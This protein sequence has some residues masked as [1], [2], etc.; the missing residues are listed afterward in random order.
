MTSQTEKA[1]H[2]KSLHKADN[3]LLLYNIWD[4]GSANAVARAG[5][6]A[7][8][9]SSWSVAAAQGYEDGEKLPL[10]Q[11]LAVATSIVRSVDVP[12]TVDFE[13]G[14]ASDAEAVGENVRRLLACGIVGFNFEDQAAHAQGLYSVE[15]QVSRIAAAR[16]AADVFGVP[17][18]INARTDIFLTAD[19]D[20][21]HAGLMEEALVREK[22]YASAGADGFFV[23]GLMDRA[24]IRQICEA[25]ILPVNIMAAGSAEEIREI[26]LLGVARVSA[27]PAPYIALMSQFE[28]EARMFLRS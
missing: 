11:L 25:D 16:Q 17:F 5:A 28:E 14:Y 2:F 3:P 9:T 24:L 1:E 6:K 13:G 27:G 20:A 8:A 26:T 10:E 15:A 22:A 23:P 21:L 7:V 12:V 19:R 18:F 4:A